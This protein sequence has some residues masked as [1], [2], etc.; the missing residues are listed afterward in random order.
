M[1]MY[2]NLVIP[3]LVRI[4]FDVVHTD[5]QMP[6]VIRLVLTRQLRLFMA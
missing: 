1:G 3:V 5:L 2:L 4:M 6:M